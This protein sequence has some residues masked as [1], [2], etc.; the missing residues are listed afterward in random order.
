M[1]P[2]PTNKPHLISVNHPKQARSQQTL[3]RLLDAAEA[4]IIEQGYDAVTIASIAR[5]AKSSVGGFYARFRDK[6]EVLRALHERLL[7][8]LEEVVSELSAPEQWEGTPL[9]VMVRGLLRELLD[10]IH[11]RR[12]LMAAFVASA[13]IHPDRWRDALAFRARVVEQIGALLLTRREEMR[14]PDP[15]RALQL[16]IQMVLAIADQHALLGLRSGTEPIEDDELVTELQR[17]TMAYLG[18]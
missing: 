10:R 7:R 13:T 4:Q 15:E 17:M 9:S 12:R 11:Y 16:A 18:A 3:D 1:P 14:H 8:E 6:E 2:T 5:A